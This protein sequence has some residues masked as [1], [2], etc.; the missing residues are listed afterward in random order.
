MPLPYV[1]PKRSTAA[2][3]RAQM[4]F[5]RSRVGRFVA[6]RVASKMDPWLERV[7]NGRVSWGMFSVPSETLKMTGAKTGEPRTLWAA[8]VYRIAGSIRLAI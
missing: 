7:T 1:N 4:R 8:S 6:R 5:A 3:M 2:V